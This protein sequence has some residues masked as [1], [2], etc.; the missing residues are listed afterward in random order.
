MRAV[1]IGAGFAGLAAALRL[2]QAGLEVTV[3]DKQEAPGGKAIGWNGVPTGPTVLTLPEVPRT[4][5]QA[6]GA[7]PPA[8]QPVSPLTRYLWPDGRT[9]APELDLE[10]TLSQLS[11]P[12]ARHYR[13]LLEQ[14]R[15]LYEGARETFIVGPPPTLS[16]LSR[17]ALRQ[18]LR[19]HPLEPLP[20]LVAS[21]PYLTP[22]FL[23]FATYL[24]ANPYRA[25][26]VLHNI[27]WVELGL[28]VYHLEG[29]MR[30][31]ADAL[32]RLAALQG[33]RFEFG[34]YVGDLE[35]RKGRVVAARAGDARY[36]A[37]IFV[38]AVDRHFTLGML[39]WPAPH[40]AL[41]TSGFALL[42]QLSEAQPLA[43]QV[44][45]SADYQAE[46]REL[47]AGRFS[48][49]PT[50][51]LHTDGETAFL[52][53]NVP[54]LRRLGEVNLEE[55][56]QFLLGKLQAVHP[57]PVREWKA[58]SPQ[59]YAFTAYQG[60]LYG[61]APHGLWGALRPGWRLG[62]LQ[63]L[64]QVGGTVHPGGGVPLAMLSGW[65]GAAWLLARSEKGRG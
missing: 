35:L 30:A 65:N 44:Y 27:A 5:F 7:E 28:G 47:E 52:L 61:K 36:P 63:N 29:G 24:G 53:V 13:R 41:G 19:A 18:G 40:Y 62:N 14:A 32:Y 50:L 48:K 23:R 49:D 33:V 15:Q 9:F 57:L 45:F 8:L 59:E 39:D 11:R 34:V 4:I 64:V 46:W 17:Y 38:S 25:P 60:A 55:Y 22:F 56:A 31:L 21:G 37:D 51:Y 16:A 3:L 26:A 43:H 6:L 54:N 10:V 20:R 12:E 2:C 58:M 42:M 1:V